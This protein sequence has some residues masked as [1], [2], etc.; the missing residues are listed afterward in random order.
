ML[1]N[2]V[3]VEYN[4]TYQNRQIWVKVPSCF[5]V[6]LNEHKKERNV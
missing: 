6:N 5:G 4:S 3:R 1:A 2:H